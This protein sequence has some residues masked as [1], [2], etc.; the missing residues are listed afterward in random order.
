MNLADAIT[1]VEAASTTLTAADGAKTS[2][3]SKFDAAKATL[4]TA[5]QADADAVAAFNKSLD[6]LIAAAS[7]AKR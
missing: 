4:D 5:T 7:A 3:Q 2:A 1:A 6:D